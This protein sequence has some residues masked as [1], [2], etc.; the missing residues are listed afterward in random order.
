VTLWLLDTNVFRALGPNGHRNVQRWLGTTDDAALRVSV[1]TLLEMRHDWEAKRKQDPVRAA[2]SLA[3]LVAVEATFKDR[4]IAIDAPIVAEWARLVGEKDKHR[5]DRTL[6][7]TAR[8]R[9]LVLV[10]RNLADFRGRN[11]RVLDPFKARPEI[12]TV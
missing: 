6:A 2:E 8:V 11:V 7:A 3:R 5:D 1:M 10:T 9:G 4:I 12:V